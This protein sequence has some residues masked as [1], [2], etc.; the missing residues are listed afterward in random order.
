MDNDKWH[1]V[2][3]SHSSHWELLLATQKTTPPMIRDKQLTWKVA[4]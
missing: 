3:D 1:P 2:N 4:V